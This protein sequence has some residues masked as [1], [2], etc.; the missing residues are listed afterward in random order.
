[1]PSNGPTRKHRWCGAFARG[2]AHQPIVLGKGGRQ[3][4]AVDSAA[5]G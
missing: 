4:K 1:L 2:E 3:I 5:R